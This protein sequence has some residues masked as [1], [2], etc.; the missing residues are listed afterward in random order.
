MYYTY[1]LKSTSIK[2]ASNQ[3]P[4][5]IVIHGAFSLTNKLFS[6]REEYFWNQKFNYDFIFTGL[7][8][9]TDRPLIWKTYPLQKGL[10]FFP[11]QREHIIVIFAKKLTNNMLHFV[12]IIKAS[13]TIYGN[14][15]YRNEK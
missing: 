10:K 11:T 4:F 12:D 1:L 14:E 3:N 2:K 15:F 5:F 8:M 13:I 9:Y 6:S 7:N